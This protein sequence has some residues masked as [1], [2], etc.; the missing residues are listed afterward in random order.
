MQKVTTWLLCA[1]A[2]LCGA[3]VFNNGGGVDV[4][5]T[6]DQSVQSKANA[7]AGVNLAAFNYTS[8]REFRI[9]FGVRF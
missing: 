7:P 4:A 5:G 3:T 2:M 1:F 9:S 6:I 8:P